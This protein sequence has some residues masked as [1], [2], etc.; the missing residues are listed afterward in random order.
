MFKAF[1][2]W[3]KS[4]S[5]KFTGA[6]EVLPEVAV[7][8]EMQTALEKWA[9]AYESP[10]QPSL[11]LAAGVAKEIATAVTLE[12]KSQISGSKRAD[13]LNEQYVRVLDK[14]RINT[15]YACAKGG[16]VF[17]PYPEGN[18]ILVQAIQ[19]DRFFPVAYDSTGNITSAYFVEQFVRGGQVFT[20]V[21]LHDY[22]PDVYKI[23][24]YAYVSKSKMVKGNQVSLESVPEWA[25]IMPE[26]EMRGA[27][28]PLFSYFKM[29]FANT[30]DANS[31]LGV[32][33]FARAMDN[34]R[35]AD[36]LYDSMLWEFK[37]SELAIMADEALFY[38]GEK[39]GDLKLP[40]GTDR[41]YRPI[42]LVG[43]DKISD[44]LSTYS[45]VIR[46]EDYIRG[47]NA[48]KQAIEFNCGLAYGTI[49]DPQQ[50]D[51]TATELKLSKQRSYATVSE[52][53]KALQT[54]LDNL[55]YAM[56]YWTTAMGL[57]P[58]GDWE[59]SYSWDDS[60]VVDAEADRQIMLNEV[61]QGIRSAESYLSEWY[62]VSEEEAKKMMPNMEQL[63]M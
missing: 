43:G 53:Q 29:P 22:H 30:V 51:R 61:A 31:P 38:L 23:K 48:I 13:Y 8:G 56:D 27:E 58:V 19:A 15:E 45:P 28:K 35:D 17:K 63:L 59:V 34:M 5:K 6:D 42:N 25:D 47:L 41:L 62:G 37:G 3:I 57:A 50:I 33:V 20:R 54:A 44:H 55:I 21:E 60:I 1:I 40:K 2:E 14:L 10:E 46:E 16:L 12:F 9:K 11:R 26:A 18:K 7:S 49:S 39:S 52:I 4:I 32:S 24:N 36:K